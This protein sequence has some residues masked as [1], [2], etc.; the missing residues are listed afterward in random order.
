MIDITGM[1]SLPG[2][3]RRSQ[4]IGYFIADRDGSPAMAAAQRMMTDVLRYAL[5]I[6]R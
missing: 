4:V 2:G 6:E 5:K 1:E 3:Q